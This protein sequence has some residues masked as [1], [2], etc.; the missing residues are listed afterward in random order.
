MKFQTSRAQCVS[1]APV[2]QITPAREF[3]SNLAQNTKQ[4][5]RKKL[6]LTRYHLPGFLQRSIMTSVV[7]VS[8][9]SEIS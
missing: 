4:R 2:P 9:F 5:E 7:S 1:S 3:I 8:Y 6:F